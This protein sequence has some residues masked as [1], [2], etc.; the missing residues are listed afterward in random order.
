MNFNKEQTMK[1]VNVSKLTDSWD[2]VNEG[3]WPPGKCMDI[4]CAF[5]YT[6]RYFLLPELHNKATI[7]GKNIINCKRMYNNIL[8]Y[9]ILNIE[10]DL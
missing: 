5:G 8:I 1:E 2:V 9:F 7:I 6:T 3:V 4:N 10:Y